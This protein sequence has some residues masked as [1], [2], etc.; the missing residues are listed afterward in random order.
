MTNPFLM[1]TQKAAI[2]DFMIANGGITPMDAFGSLGI[3]KLSTRIGEMK[4]EGVE[5][6]TETVKGHNRVGKPTRYCRYAL[7]EEA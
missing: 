5:I 7:R 6:T 4:A 2:L 1:G 3:T